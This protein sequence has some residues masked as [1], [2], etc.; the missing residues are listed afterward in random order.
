MFSNDTK[1][2]SIASSTLVALVFLSFALTDIGFKLSSLHGLKTTLG[3]PTKHWRDWSNGQPETILAT[4]SNLK[5]IQEDPS[6][7]VRWLQQ[8]GITIGRHPI[9][10]IGDSNYLGA[11]KNLRARLDQ[12]GYGDD[13]VVLC[14]DDACAQETSYHGWRVAL[15]PTRAVLQQVAEVKVSIEAQ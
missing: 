8:S 15:D 2:W 10:T 4:G 3:Q 7:F 9:I 12:Y 1:L 5:S 13:L 11:L 14:L 6:D